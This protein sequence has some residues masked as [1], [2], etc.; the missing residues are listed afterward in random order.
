[1]KPVATL[2]GRA[3]YH[4][5]G[6]N[7]VV[8]FSDEPGWHGRKLTEAFAL[9]GLQAL[10]VSLSDCSFDLSS[11]AVA[12]DKT[13]KIPGV[14]LQTVKGV[15]VR[16][17]AGGQLEE[18]ILRLNILHAL[19]AMNIPVFNTGRA[20]ERT[21]DKGMTSFLLRQQGLPTMDTWVT[22]SQEHALQIANECISTTGSVVVKPIFGSQGKGVMR[23][24]D[25]AEFERIEPVN[26]VYYLQAYVRPDGQTYRDWRVFVIRGVAIAAMQRSSKHWVTNRAQGAECE[27]FQPDLDVK[28][29]AEKAA[30]ALNVDYAG[31]DLMRNS[32][33][34]WL[35]SEVNGIPAWQGLQRTCKVN[36]AAK[37]VEAFLDKAKRQALITANA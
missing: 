33:G 36:V 29:L 11:N 26:G 32:D 30:A 37:L 1:M 23:V 12:D 19:E 25:I 8:I 9:T 18:V 20:I 13:L 34:D 15:F 31:V 16:G 14:D 17:V 28:K 27:P 3:Q 35:V 7:Q 22:G 24:S 6:Q 2:T 5:D 4:H 21:V 10:Y